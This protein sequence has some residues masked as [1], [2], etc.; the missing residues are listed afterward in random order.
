MKVFSVG[1]AAAVLLAGAAPGT[2]G[3]STD[4]QTAALQKRVTKLEH[5]LAA[6]QKSQTK[7]QK[8]SE[9]LV[10]IAVL[11]AAGVACGA[12]VTADAFETTWGVVD[13]LAQAT[14]GKV[15]FGPQ[16]ALND[17]Q[18]CGDLTIQRQVA[19]APP[20]LAS[21]SKVIDFFYAP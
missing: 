4:P 16:A 14:Q 2:A 13:Q 7:L 18:S 15:Y 19:S 5:E 20:S 8:A 12:A 3:R 6:M 1:I 21:L 10:T 11:T 17:Q 9:D